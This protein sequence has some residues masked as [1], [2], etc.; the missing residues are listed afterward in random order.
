MADAD[1]QAYDDLRVLYLRLLRDY[2]KLLWRYAHARAAI[3]NDLW[4]HEQIIKRV[5]F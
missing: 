1:E 5:P 2:E 3:D 4:A